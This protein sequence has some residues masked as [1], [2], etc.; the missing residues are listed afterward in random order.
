MVKLLIHLQSVS[1]K[2]TFQ[3]FISN[4]TF[5]RVHCQLVS[6]FGTGKQNRNMNSSLM[7]CLNLP[8]KVR[9]NKE[10]KGIIQYMTQKSTKNSTDNFNMNTQH[11]SFTSL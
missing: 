4:F 11:S 1:S 5:H 2:Y 7:A 10:Q 3:K 9:D 8:K 6:V